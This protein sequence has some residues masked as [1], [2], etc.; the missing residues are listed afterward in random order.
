MLLTEAFQCVP[1]TPPPGYLS[2]EG[3][4]T[5]SQDMGKLSFLPLGILFSFFFVCG[6]FVVCVCVGGDLKRHSDRNLKQNKA[7]SA[8]VESAHKG[9]N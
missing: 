3:E 8:C 4:T 9:V 7:Q 1:D 2:E 5:D 6:F